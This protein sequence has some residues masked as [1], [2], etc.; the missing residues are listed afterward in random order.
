MTI[1]KNDNLFV[2]YKDPV[3]GSLKVL[4]GKKKPAAAT[5]SA[6]KEKLP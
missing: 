6:Q 4:V 3:D 1:D 5:T 2:S